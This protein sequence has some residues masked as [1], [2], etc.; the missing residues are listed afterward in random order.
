[1]GEPC[2]LSRGLVVAVVALWRAPRMITSLLSLHFGY[3]TKS[4][5]YQKASP[6][7]FAVVTKKP[8]NGERR[9]TSRRSEE[10]P[11]ARA[12]V[13]SGRVRG[14]GR[15][16]SMSRASQLS[17]QGPPALLYLLKKCERNGDICH[18][19]AFYACDR[20]GVCYYY[21]HTV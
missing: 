2:L 11:P 8:E 12:L 18:A 6:Q 3:S 14:C 9:S 13:G 16:A 21:V 5:W 15:A 19:Y 20:S 17:L 10:P 7:T 4:L 1:M